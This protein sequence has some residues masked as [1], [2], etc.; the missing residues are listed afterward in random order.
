[1]EE[2]KPRKTEE[3]HR[4]L[5]YRSSILKGGFKLASSTN[6]SIL[7]NSNKIRPIKSLDKHYFN[8][9]NSRWHVHSSPKSN[10]DAI[11]NL[12]DNKPPENLEILIQEQEPKKYNGDL[13]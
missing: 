4:S 6:A 13:E 5:S 1:M 9:S 8:V 3:N 12:N 10:F 7:N 11:P 2:E